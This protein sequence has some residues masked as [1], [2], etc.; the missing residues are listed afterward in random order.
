[1]KVYLKEMNFGTEFE[2]RTNYCVFLQE[3][4]LGRSKERATINIFVSETKHEE[5]RCIFSYQRKD[6]SSWIKEETSTKLI[7]VIDCIP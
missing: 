2:E 5:L 4:G 1:M 3:L 6:H 7:T